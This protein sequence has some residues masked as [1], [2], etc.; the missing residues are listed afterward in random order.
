MYGSADI[1]R[2]G[3]A[4]TRG[5]LATGRGGLTI[6]PIGRLEGGHTL[7]AAGVGVLGI[8]TDSKHAA[9][10]ARTTPADRAESFSKRVI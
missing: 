5:R 10:S 3:A 8:G 6:I 2:G 1:G 4:L 7:A 9:F